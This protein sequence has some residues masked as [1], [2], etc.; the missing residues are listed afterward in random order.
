MQ[1][2]ELA[3]RRSGRPETISGLPRT[4]SPRDRG[5]LQDHAL[6]TCHCGYVFEAAVSTTVDCPHCGTGQAW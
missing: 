4:R 1:R 5:P 2:P 3:L 6:Y